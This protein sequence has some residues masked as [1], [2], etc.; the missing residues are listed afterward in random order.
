MHTAVSFLSGSSRLCRIPCVQV[1][2]DHSVV[3]GPG[4]QVAGMRPM[5]F[6]L[7]ER[8]RCRPGRSVPFSNRAG[9]HLRRCRTCA[10]GTTNQVTS[11]LLVRRSGL[12]HPRQERFL[13][14]PP[15]EGS[16][17]HPTSDWRWKHRTSSLPFT[18]IRNRGFVCSTGCHRMIPSGDTTS[19]ASK[20]AAVPARRVPIAS[21]RTGRNIPVPYRPGYPT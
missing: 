15:S 19:S 4:S 7:P 18:A 11:S 20:T 12:F 8:C 2:T 5:S 9:A 3:P 13:H 6:R 16:R 21:H 1:Q 14:G 17:G 10:F